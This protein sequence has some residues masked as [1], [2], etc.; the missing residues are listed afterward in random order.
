MKRFAVLVLASLTCLLLPTSVAAAPAH[1]LPAATAP[2]SLPESP[3]DGGGRS[4]VIRGTPDADFITVQQDADGS[5][6]VNVNG[7]PQTVAD[8]DIANL[9]VDGG[10]GDDT[11]TVDPVVTAGQFILGGAGDDTIMGGN[12][13]DVIYGGPGEDLIVCGAG[14]CYVDGGPG[15]DHIFGGPGDDIIFAGDGNDE[16]VA[17]DGDGLMAGGPGADSFS[18]GSDQARIVA[19]RD[20]TVDSPGKVTLA[21]LTSTDAAGNEPGTEL[22]VAGGATFRQQVDSD[23]T[24]LLS[25]P[26]GRRLLAAIDDARPR[27][28]IERSDHGDQTTILVP[29]AAFLQ[30]GGLLG[31]GSAS[32]ISYDPFETVIDGGTEA[33][34]VRPPLVGLFHELVHAYNA[35]TG[36]LQPGKAGGVFKLELQAVGLPFNGIAY[37]LSPSSDPDDQNPRGFTENEFRALLRLPERMAY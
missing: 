35:A 6:L 26:A 11:I 2:L 22:R 36:T 32:T 29:A 27:V 12:G 5:L 8:T 31:S 7:A 16:L 37:R 1:G 9:V 19:Q 34:Q 25:L 30:A 18:G 20:E 28:M 33:W 24:A 21:P 10:A 15:D 17:G 14:D 3:A 13:S 23:I 4:L